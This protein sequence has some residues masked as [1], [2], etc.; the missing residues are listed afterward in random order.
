MDYKVIGLMSGT[1][2]DGLDVALVHFQ[3]GGAGDWKYKI[4]CAESIPYSPEWRERLRN[5]YYLSAEAITALD[6]SYGRYLGEC[7]REFAD[8]N[9]LRSVDFV[10]SHGHTVFHR[11]AAGYNL[12]IGSGAHLHAVSGFGVVC[13]FRTMDIAFGGQGAPLVPIGDRLLF[14][15]YD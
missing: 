11:P 10:A 1:S 12:Q 15:E 14:G 2:L 9:R 13:D 8:R 6:A 4:L 7:A 5:A 3:G